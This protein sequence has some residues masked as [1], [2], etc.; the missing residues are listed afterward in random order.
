MTLI[1][2][3]EFNWLDYEIIEPDLLFTIKDVGTFLVIKPKDGLLF[4][5]KF[6]LILDDFE[7][8]LADNVDFFA[9]S[10][11]G[12][13]YHYAIND[14]PELKPLKNLGNAKYRS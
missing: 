5:E 6:Y 3:L 11:G 10:F 1:D 12:K 2:H 8:E 14:E 4:D 13:W 7:S 9:F